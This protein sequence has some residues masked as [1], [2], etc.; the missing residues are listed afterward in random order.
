MR[1]S[2]W[3]FHPL[4]KEQTTTMG[5]R[6]R[7]SF[8]GF[9]DLRR[10]GILLVLSPPG[11]ETNHVLPIAYCLLPMAYYLLPKTGKQDSL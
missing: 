10:A 9:E 11:Q 4:A 8:R 6:H 5:T 2:L 1:A 3:S 7:T